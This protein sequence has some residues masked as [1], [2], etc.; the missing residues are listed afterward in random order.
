MGKSKTMSNDP[1]KDLRKGGIKLG[2][3]E[4]MQIGLLATEL[5]KVAYIVMAYETSSHITKINLKC[6][7][8]P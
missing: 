3:L 5:I 2:L 1:S 4:D 6:S 8:N 7:Y